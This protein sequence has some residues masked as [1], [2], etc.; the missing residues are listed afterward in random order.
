MEKV[1]KEICLFLQQMTIELKLQ[2]R[3]QLLVQFVFS[4]FVVVQLEIDINNVLELF[5]LFNSQLN[6][7]FIII[8][9]NKVSFKIIFKLVLNLFTIWQILCTFNKGS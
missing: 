9:L 8:M 2:M 1:I 3:R 7:E 4:D 6:D 5:K